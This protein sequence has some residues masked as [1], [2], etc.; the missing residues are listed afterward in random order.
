M[1]KFIFALLLL[2]L[3]GDI[4]NFLFIRKLLKR[5]EKVE[6]V[7]ESKCPYLTPLLADGYKPCLKGCPMYQGNCYRWDRCF[8]ARRMLN[9][10]D[11]G[12]DE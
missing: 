3:Y 12:K 10:K 8:G 2:V 7:T 11:G 1:N 5:V 4:M 6:K 9:E